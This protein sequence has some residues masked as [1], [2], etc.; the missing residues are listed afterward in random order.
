MRHGHGRA[1][2]PWR[3]HG[4][5]SAGTAQDDGNGIAVGVASGRGGVRNFRGRST[6]RFGPEVKD[7]KSLMA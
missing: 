2:V 6:L 5:R 1:H 3:C 4:G 7:A